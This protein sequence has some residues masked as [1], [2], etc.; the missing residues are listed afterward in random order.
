MSVYHHPDWTADGVFIEFI[1]FRERE[2]AIDALSAA[3]IK[4]A[5]ARPTPAE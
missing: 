1:E 2:T 4:D 3:V 5:H